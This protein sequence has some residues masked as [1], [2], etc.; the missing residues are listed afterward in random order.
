MDVEDASRVA[1]NE[2][3]GEDA[4]EAREEEVVGEK[5]STACAIAASNASREGWALWA[6]T[7]VSIPRAAAHCSPPAA[8][9]RLE[10]TARKSRPGS[11]STR[12][13]MLCPGRK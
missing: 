7:R 13:R 6:T 12:A 10:I 11:A 8:P 9:E 3:L 2:A 4:H 5:A 1:M